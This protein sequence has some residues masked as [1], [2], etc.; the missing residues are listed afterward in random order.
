[1]RPHATTSHLE[2]KMGVCAM[3]HIARGAG[4]PDHVSS[5]NG[6]PRRD[7]YPTKMPGLGVNPPGMTDND[8]ISI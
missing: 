3:G 2:M 4:K 7:L 5:M 6:R 1:M 8:L